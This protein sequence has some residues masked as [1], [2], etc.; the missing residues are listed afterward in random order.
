MVVVLQCL[1]MIIKHKKR[2]TV[3]KPIIVAV[4]V[5]ILLIGVGSIILINNK[6]SKSEAP[7]S[8][9][10]EYPKETVNVAPPTEEEAAAGDA[11]KEEVVKQENDD[12]EGQPEVGAAQ[13]VITYAGQYG[14]SVEVGAYMS[15][16]FES[17]GTCTLSLTK[18]GVV[19]S[20]QVKAVIAARSTDCPTMVIGRDQLSPGTWRATVDYSSSGTSGQSAPRAIEV[21]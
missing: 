18:D 16:T 12:G 7:V 13:V 11:I 6:N 8:S 1:C 10:G 4:V 20:V 15:N 21:T 14:D 2:F 9:M 19:K 3:T 17:G 5:A